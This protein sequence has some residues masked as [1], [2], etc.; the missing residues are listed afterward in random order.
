MALTHSILILTF[1]PVMNQKCEKGF[2]ISSG[3]AIADNTNSL[4]VIY[5]AAV[6]PPVSEIIQIR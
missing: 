5:L 3:R 1:V 4:Q 6:V 2:I